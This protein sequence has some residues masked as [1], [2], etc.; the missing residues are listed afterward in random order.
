MCSTR[1]LPGYSGSETSGKLTAPT[2]DPLLL[3]LISL[4]A[5]SM[6]MFSCASSVLPPMCGV[7]RTLSMPLDGLRGALAVHDRGVVLID[8]HALRPAQVL[9]PHAFQL[10]AS[11]FHD[12]LAA[13]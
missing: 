5:T 1:F 2:V 8:R 6:P 12:R 4:L 13:S 10:D 11:L 9:Q 7:S 3:Y